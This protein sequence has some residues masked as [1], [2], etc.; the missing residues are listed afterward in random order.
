MVLIWADGP[1]GIRPLVIERVGRLPLFPKGIPGKASWGIAEVVEAIPP[2]S[3]LSTDQSGHMTVV[4][5][6]PRSIA[7][8]T[9]YLLT[10]S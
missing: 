6:H 3:S 9:E 2:L 5:W 8:V 4:Q 10:F 7:Q 1:G